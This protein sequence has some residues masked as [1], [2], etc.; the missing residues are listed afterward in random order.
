MVLL[1]LY[2]T[3]LVRVVYSIAGLACQPGQRG[4]LQHLRRLSLL[5]KFYAWC[6]SQLLVNALRHLRCFKSNCNCHRNYVFV[7]QAPLVKK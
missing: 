7:H 1:V 3:V 4:L 5:A 6:L 2:G